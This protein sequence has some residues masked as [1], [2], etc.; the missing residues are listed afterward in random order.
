MSEARRFLHPPRTGGSSIV[1]GWNLAK[2]EYL[3]HKPPGDEDGWRYGTTR[4]P[5]DRAVSLFHLAHR[6]PPPI[7]GFAVWLF[8]GMHP[9][10]ESGRRFAPHVCAPTMDWLDG[11]DFVV[12]FESRAEHLAEL[13]G[14]LGRDPAAVL[15]RHA[16][17]SEHRE[18]T[19]YRTYYD[20][21][22]DAVELVRELYRRDIEA[23][24]YEFDG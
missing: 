24:G 13:A 16:N 4:N 20:G 10:P 18:R 9:H 19:D 11:A 14:L 23:F 1:R 3:G 2:P 12:R 21:H 15:E 22:P 6:G 17:A 5:W 8:A 7:D